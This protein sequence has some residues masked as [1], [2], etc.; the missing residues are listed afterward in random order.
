MFQKGVKEFNLNQY[1]LAIE[2]FEKAESIYRDQI[3]T[4]W[5]L[6]RLYV[7]EGDVEK[8]TSYYETALSL[9][10]VI[11]YENEDVI[12]EALKQE[13]RNQS[14]EKIQESVIFLHML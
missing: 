1:K 10:D 11:D 9:I 2:Q 13:S 6:G 14:L 12:Q 5:N 4:Y 7:L 8:G 3:L